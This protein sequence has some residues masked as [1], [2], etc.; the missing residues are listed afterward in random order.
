MDAKDIAI[1]PTISQQT[2][3]PL[4]A[5]LIALA[6]VTQQIDALDGKTCTGHI[7]WR[8]KKKLDKPNKMYINHNMNQACPLH[9]TPEKGKRI[10]VYIGTDPNK[11]KAAEIDLDAEARLVKLGQTRRTLESALSRATSRLQDYYRTLQF[12]CPTHWNPDTPL[13]PDTH[14]SW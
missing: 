1:L 2:K 10:R 5:A 7:W 11:Q 6:E 14:Q 4:T 9:G 3:T 12:T 13:E 8:D